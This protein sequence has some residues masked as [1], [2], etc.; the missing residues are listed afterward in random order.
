MKRSD[1]LRK[2]LENLVKS[3]APGQKLP[4]VRRLLKQYGVG[5]ATFQKAVAPLRESGW[6]RIVQG[7]GIYAG[8]TPPAPKLRNVDIIYFGNEKNLLQPGYPRDLMQNLVLV[9]GQENIGTKITVIPYNTTYEDMITKIRRLET[10]AVI[11]LSPMD[12]NF[13]NYMKNKRIPYAC[14]TPE[15]TQRI[16]NSVYIDERQVARIAVEELFQRGHRRIALLHMMQPGYLIYGWTLRQL[17]F[18]DV[19]AE[20][21]LFLPPAYSRF[22]GY[23]NRSAAQAIGEIL[24][25]GAEPTALIASECGIS[26]IYHELQNRGI[27]IGEDISVISIDHLDDNRFLIPSLASVE[28]SRRKLSLEAKR[29]L[30][31]SLS[32]P[33]AVL[34]SV[35]VPPTFIPGNS[36]RFI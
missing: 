6:L 26:G 19:L 13:I 20:K 33:D 8:G 29:I 25:S 22:M 27:R 1:N 5:I 17:G 16:S 10:H 7:S 24:D 30:E 3:A 36:I 34:P 21:E 28:I 9:F 35:D 4:S 11:A 23:G 14:I 32:S 15:L 12:M 18:Y 31:K 2:Q